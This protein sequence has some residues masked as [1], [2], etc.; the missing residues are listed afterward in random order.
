MMRKTRIKRVWAG[1]IVFAAALLAGAVA[2]AAEGKDPAVGKASY[3]HLCAL[4]HGA[5]GKGDGP[6][7]ASLSPN[8]ADL[9][10]KRYVDWL[11]DDDLRELIQEGGSALGGALNDDDVENVIADVRSLAK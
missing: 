4:C 10:N 1:G 6:A 7:A 9:G 11:K 3:E 8:P 2:V 5:A